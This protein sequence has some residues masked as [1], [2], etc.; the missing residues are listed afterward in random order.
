MNLI[1]F[2][3]LSARVAIFCERGF[4]S[5]NVNKGINP[6]LVK[7]WIEE[8]GIKAD[9][10]GEREIREGKLTSF[11]YSILIYLYGSTFP[12]DLLTNFMTFRKERG[13]LI[14]LGVPFTRPVRRERGKYLDTGSSNKYLAHKMG[15]GVGRFWRYPKG[16]VRVAIPST[17]PLGI[18]QLSLER[19]DVQPA[20]VFDLNSVPSEDSIIPV[21]VEKENG[22]PIGYPI[23]IVRHL[24]PQFSGV[25][26]ILIE[27]RLFLEN[28]VENLYILKALITLGVLY[29]LKEKKQITFFEFRK[30]RD[31]FISSF[32][33]PFEIAEIKPL[34]IEKKNS[35]FPSPPY[36]P[37]TLFVIDLR[38][39]RRE[40]WFPFLSLQGIVNRV[41]PRIYLI[42]DKEDKEWLDW[43][44]R[45]KLVYKTLILS[46]KEAFKKFR[47]EIKGGC[48]FDNSVPFSILVATMI[49]SIKD[50]VIFGDL[51]TAK[52][53]QIP[54]KIDLRGKFKTNF[55]ALQFVLDSLLTNL[56]N[57]LLSCAYPNGDFVKFFD[58]LVANRGIIFWLAG[59]KDGSSP[60][61]RPLEERRIVEK[62]W[63]ITP[64][65]IPILGFFWGGE[66][67][68]I[69]E[70]EG[71]KLISKYGKFMV[72][73]QGTPNLTVHSAIR[74]KRRFRQFHRLRER[75][76]SRKI[77]GT[78]I[79]SDGDNL[80]VWYTQFKHFW[81]KKHRGEFPIG[82]TIS[83]AMYE[84][85]PDLVYYFYSNKSD[86]DYFVCGNN[87]LGLVYPDYYGSKF[88]ERE[89]VLR[90]YLKLT[91][92]YMRRLDL[93]CMALT[94]MDNKD[95]QE[96]WVRILRPVVGVFLDYGRASKTTERNANFLVRGVPFMRALTK[97]V[98]GGRREMILHM[99]KELRSLNLTPPAF[100]YAFVRNWNYDPDML[101]EVKEELKEFHFVTPYEIAK[102]YLRK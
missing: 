73:N 61:S 51:L 29:I 9:L 14:C 70:V 7:K 98:R 28:N 60:L 75:Y 47:K 16:E 46:K 87:G 65:N 43:L 18:K 54:I 83:P 96:E 36:P 88:K 58:Y 57:S 66:G 41:K 2:L 12:L 26:D 100:V 49:A 72:V 99:V 19:L 90:E 85:L 38:G 68:G 95:V 27:S 44:E 6:Y 94:T 11:K 23:V 52:F 45:Q 89:K 82:W 17:E 39:D 42:F 84:L 25:I 34:F 35:I 101:F 69:G 59:E 55:D 79:F 10:L 93:R 40:S 32:R 5:Y 3:F 13:S 31:E 15:L 86:N 1:L 50:Y 53:F 78:F 48:L 22:M 64:V 24:C 37:D 92:K 4:P 77:Y 56:N 20:Y 33:L 71:I 67:I 30:K 80:S 8:I 74:P 97:P 76:D 91:K 102:F 21:L 62:I 81:K 63:S